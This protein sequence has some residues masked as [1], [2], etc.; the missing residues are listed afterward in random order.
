MPAADTVLRASI[1]KGVR[2]PTVSELF[3]GSVSGNT[4]VNNNPALKPE[5]SLAAEL[6]LERDFTIGRSSGILRA[7]LFEDDIRD[8]I[9]NQTNTLVFPA[10]TNIQNIGRVRTRGVELSVNAGNVGVS[11][12]DLS[13]NI[14]FARSVILDNVNNPATVGKHWVRVPRVRANL[15]VT[16]RGGERWT[17]SLAVRHSGRQYNNLDNSDVNQDTFGGT[18][19]Y[20]VWDAKAQ[21]RIS[22]NIDASLG[23]NNLFNRKYY[24]FHPYPGR[25]VFG[26]LHASF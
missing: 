3:Q 16:Y 4:L 25:T 17:S 11:G 20:T 23:V 18:S 2:F 6:T 26:E 19:S 9:L 22:R 12:F 5:R 21:Y 8:T 15:T 1:G 13:G 7:S 24:V 10:V 14:A